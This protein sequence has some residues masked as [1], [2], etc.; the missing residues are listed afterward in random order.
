MSLFYSQYEPAQPEYKPHDPER[1]A[2]ERLFVEVAGA[3]GEVDWMELKGILDRSMKDCKLIHHNF[4]N[5]YVKKKSQ[6]LCL[7][8]CCFYFMAF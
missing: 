1:V 6:L 7:T 3:D 4:K 8:L 2:L 5:F